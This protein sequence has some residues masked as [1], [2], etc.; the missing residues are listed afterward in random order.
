MDPCAMAGYHQVPELVLEAVTNSVAY[1]CASVEL[2]GMLVIK[3]HDSLAAPV[4]LSITPPGRCN[5][6]NLWVVLS[7]P[8]R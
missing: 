3:T 4:P 5:L 2:Y 6:T 8:H 1:Q 7:G